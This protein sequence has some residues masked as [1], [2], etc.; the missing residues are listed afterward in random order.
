MIFTG[1]GHKWRN[2]L[3][4][5]RRDALTFRAGIAKV[6]GFNLLEGVSRLML[7]RSLGRVGETRRLRR[8]CATVFNFIPIGF[9][10]LATPP[11]IS[12]A[13]YAALRDFTVTFY[14]GSNSSKFSTHRMESHLG[15]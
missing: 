9:F 4:V 1:Y 3:I 10:E 12:I 15:T 13:I 11:E 14:T 2:I 7:L 8:V 5:L 6:I